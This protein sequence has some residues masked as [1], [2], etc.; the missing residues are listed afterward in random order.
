MEAQLQEWLNICVRLVHVVAAIMWIGDSF[1]FMFLDKSLEP[2]REPHK[3]DVLGEMHMT[4]GG[5]FYQLVKRRSL[6]QEEL[7][8]T[9][10]WFM[11]ESYTTWMSGFTLLV[12][13]YYMGNAALLID[14]NV[15]QVTPWQGVG[16]SLGLLVAGWVVYDRLC[17]ALGHVPVVLAVVCAALVVGAGF[18]LL[19]VFSPRGAF[20]H[21]GAMMATCM[22]G[23]VF[24]RIIPG[25]KRMLADTLAGRPVDI[26]FGAKAKTRSTHN[27]YIT[28]PVLLTMISNHF[29]SLYG[30]DHAWIVLA[31]LLVFGGGLKYLM[32][33]KGKS[34][35]AL[36]AATV[37]SLGGIVGLTAPA[38]DASAEKYAD[39]PDVPFARAWEIVQARC[40][41]C[42]AQRPAN[43]AFPV[44][45]NGVA[46]DTAEAVQRHAPRIFARAV[47]TRTMPLANQ[48]GMTDA[49]R[50]QLGAWFAKGARAGDYDKALAPQPAASAAPPAQG[51]P[52]E[53]AKA[54]YAQRCVSCHGATGRGDGPAAQGLP[55]KPRDFA[56]KAWQAS[57]DDALVTK[58][59]VQGGTAIGKN[60]AMPPNP[61]LAG[62]AAVVAE[63]VKLLRGMAAP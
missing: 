14:P 21:V 32:N 43:P 36:I 13:V 4:H 47:S 8:P 28:L 26:S 9:L 57:V 37:V 6:S 60:S 56:D 46:L 25:Q 44:P 51:S 3:G 58:A 34:H 11:W 48:T 52:A 12:V 22:S 5:G 29:P 16:L 62:Q 30:N 20:I 61:D 2:P 41:S 27:H 40:S 35:P 15:L 7:P 49:E 45:P 55:V 39:A 24:F 38:A 59:V 10:H 19:Q 18:G 31:C 50:D 63:L 53:Q 42:H 33:F 17:E 1:L 54:L 23:N